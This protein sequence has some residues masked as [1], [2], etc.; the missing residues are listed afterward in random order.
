MRAFTQPSTVVAA[1]PIVRP[2]DRVLTRFSSAAGA[3]L[4]KMAY[5]VEETR[6]L[7]AFRDSLLPKLISGE[8]RIKDE[9]RLMERAV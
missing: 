3:L 1:T 6:T 7:A 9:E 4:R 2:D 8:L 5:N